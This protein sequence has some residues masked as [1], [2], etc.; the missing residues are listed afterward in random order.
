[1]S[2]S[3][4]LF[5]AAAAGLCLTVGARAQSVTLY[6][7]MDMSAGQFQN[8]GGDKVWRAD[9]G[10]MTTSFLGFK[11]SEDLGGGLKAKFAINT[12]LRADQGAAGRFNGDAFWARDAYVGLSGAFGTTTLGRI[13]TPLFV[14]TLAFNAFG[15]S[16]AF[17]PSIRQLFTPSL[18]PFFGDTGWN[19]SV[20]YASSDY[21]G[22][23]FNLQANLGEGAAGTH[24]KNLGAN[25]LYFKGP[26]GAT[27][28]W[29][30]VKNGTFGE[31]AGFA[32][33]T[34]WQLGVSY[35]LTV[36]KLFGQFT[37]V[38]TSAAT[39]T[40]TNLWSLGTAVPLGGGKVLAQYGH[41][42][43][44]QPGSDP[45]N[46]TLSLGYDYSLSKNTDVYAVYMNDRRTG[47][48]DG[49]SLAAGVRLRF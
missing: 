35:D 28:A 8:A 36:A 33:Q 3:L 19:N 22:L 11:G 44:H 1:M 34:T 42:T 46:K 20:A 2:R 29:Q 45:T 39:D 13:T 5:A 49:N 10:S 26:L 24:G 4:T 23:S 17:S 38:R 6:G 40:K 27:F 47:V 12:F 15:D 41:A 32:G 37:Q 43:A 18:L 48:D 30:Q 7:L 25:V 21:D 16:F 31:P 14:S 9:S